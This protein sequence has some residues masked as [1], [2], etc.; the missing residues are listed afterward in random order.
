MDLQKENI[1]ANLNKIEKIVMDIINNEKDKKQG[2]LEANSLFKKVI[3]DY[4]Y[5]KRNEENIKRR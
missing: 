5:L 4:E 3:E 1:K 2:L